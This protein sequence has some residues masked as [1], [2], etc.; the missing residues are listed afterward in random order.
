MKYIFLSLI[1]SFSFYKAISQDY[2]KV[3]K[4]VD[5][6]PHSFSKP[7]KLAELINKDFSTDVD[8][9]RAIYRWIAL[10]V[11]YDVKTYF[12][13]QKT[14]SY[15]YSTKEEKARKEKEYELSV[16]LE[17]LK[18]KKAVCQGYSTLFKNL[19]D[20]TGV[21]CVAI[22]GYS[23]VFEGDI[24][25]VP[26]VTDHSWNAVKINNKWGLVD[27]TWGAGSVDYSKK[28]FVPQFTDVYFLTNPEQFYLKHYPENKEWLFIDKSI[29]DFADL[30]L[31]Y[32]DKAIE[33][34]T[35]IKPQKGILNVRPK[36]K[37]EFK[38]KTSLDRKDLN[39]AYKGEKYASELD[40]K[41][42]DGILSFE[43]PT[44]KSTKFLTFF[45][46]GSAIIT[47]RIDKK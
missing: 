17:T 27:A 14:V 43:V 30:P 28:V 11:A 47:Y 4:I 42:K 26:K 8:K 23:K 34:I 1:I 24:G 41:Y 44:D 29:Q 2:Q 31:Y 40:A 19:C 5:K 32:S 45:Y 12:S 10:Y 6:Y 13:G 25:K 3:D 21:E 16:A 38:W 20:L 36:D 9:A 18:K 33:D 46:K 37:I 39:Y 22:Q 35:I 15:T 7:E